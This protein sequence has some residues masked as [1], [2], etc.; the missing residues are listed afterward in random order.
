MRHFLLCCIVL[1]IHAQALYGKPLLVVVLMVKNEA[2]VITQT[3]QPFIDGG[4]KDFI[5]FDTGS[6]DGTQD[7]ARNLFQ[8]HNLI[9][10]HVIEEPFIDFATSRNHAIE[11]AESLF[12]DATFIIMP[13]A[14][15]YMHGIEELIQFC[16]AHKDDYQSS[17]FVSIRNEHCSFYTHRLIRCHKNVRFVGMVHEVLNQLTFLKVPDSCYFEWGSS[18]K[19]K[20]KTAQRWLRDKDLLLKGFAENPRDPRTLFYLA[21]TCDCLGDLDNA[22]NYYELRTKINGW[23]EENYMAWYRLG[24]VAHRLESKNCTVPGPYAIEC[25]LNAFA[26]RPQR[27]EPLI[28][29]SGYY[30]ARNEIDKAFEYAQRAAHIPYP[31]TEILF[32]DRSMYS[33]TRYEILAKCALRLGKYE[34]AQWA[35]QQALLAKPDAL[36]LQM[37]LEC[38]NSIG[39]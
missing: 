3:L 23:P 8:S 15:W 32:V 30:L 31:V 6:N 24:L 22:Y 2:T 9:N 35:V 20:E 28:Q 14:E 25:Y 38:Y 18:R 7:I 1:L 21:Q 4:V 10:A 34:I 12:P 39:Q 36:Y 13:D 26:M 27:A 19:G 17:Y 37:M 29:V 16:T 5:V 11:V 33:F